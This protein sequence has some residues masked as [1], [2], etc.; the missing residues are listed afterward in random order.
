LPHKPA[1]ISTND[2]GI[3]TLLIQGGESVACRHFLE[4]VQRKI[5]LLADAKETKGVL[6]AF[7]DTFLREAIPE[8]MPSSD[9]L[10]LSTLGQQVASDIESL[11]KPVIAAITGDCLGV[12]LEL[13]LAADFILASVNAKLGFPGIK[14]N[15]IPFCGGSQRL[16]RLVGKSVAKEMIF[17]GNTLDAAEAYRIGLVNRLYGDESLL[18][19]GEALLR[20]ISGNSAFAIRVGGEIINAGYDIDLKTACILERD[21]FALIFSTPDKR[22][23]M[24][25]FLEKREPLF[26]S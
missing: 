15:M 2:S 21:A 12:P 24:S 4:S 17:T 6:L 16:A 13:A 7:R 18:P 25:A 26:G 11:G 9:L 20:K 23:G 8:A 19:E 10:T 1:T 22:E 3:A 14:E 5:R